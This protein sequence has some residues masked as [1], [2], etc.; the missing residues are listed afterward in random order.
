[1]S[2]HQDLSP[3]DVQKKGPKSLG[4]KRD[5]P[6]STRNRKLN[7]AFDVIYKGLDTIT[8]DPHEKEELLFDMFTSTPN[9]KN[10]FPIFS[11][12]Q[13]ARQIGKDVIEVLKHLERNTPIRKIFLKLFCSNVPAAQICGELEISNKTYER[14]QSLIDPIGDLQLLG[15]KKIHNFFSKEEID[16]ITGF[17]QWKCPPKSGTTRLLQKCDNAELYDSYAKAVKQHNENVDQNSGTKFKIRSPKTLFKFREKLHVKVNPKIDVFECSVCYSEQFNKKILEELYQQ[18]SEGDNSD[19]T[20]DRIEDLEK[21]IQTAK[22]HKWLNQHQRKELEKQ[23]EAL[24]EKEVILIMDFFSFKE[25]GAPK[26]MQVFVITEISV[27]VDRHGNRKTKR[28]FFDFFKIHK[29][30]VSF[31]RQAF[32]WYMVERSPAKIKKVILWTDNGPHHFRQRRSQFFMSTMPAR[33]NLEFE[34]NFFCEQH[35]HNICDSHA[36]TIK[37]IYRPVR[38]ETGKKVPT[39]DELELILNQAKESGDYASNFEAIKMDEIDTTPIICGEIK[40]I[41]SLHHFRYTRE[42]G[43]IYAKKYTDYSQPVA[44]NHEKR[45]FQ[46]HP[47]I[48]DLGTEEESDN[49]DDESIINE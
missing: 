5:L 12:D 20:Q 23:E 49:E 3:T 30:D 40:G 25:Y 7:Q 21:D 11:S 36:A 45:F 24:K 15:E 9:G 13:T 38:K 35:A 4:Y 43:V 6:Y 33:F 46:K 32:T 47:E 2:N 22:F 26:A 19:E 44:D 28:R 18:R 27:H 34:W 41:E 42:P 37:A 48:E 31:F 17:F 29:N 8:T 14:A 10:T 16:F 39:E 1:M